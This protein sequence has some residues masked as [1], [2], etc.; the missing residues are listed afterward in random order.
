MKK[1]LV[2]L[3][4]SWG[5]RHGGL[6]VVNYE[7]CQHFAKCESF[8]DHI[9]CITL[10]KD[11][12]LSQIDRLH[13]FG[14]QENAL[15]DNFSTSDKY[16]ILEI[17]ENN[18]FVPICFIGHDAK[19]GPIANACTSLY[20]NKNESQAK[21]VVFHHM[22]YSSY[23]SLK[24]F[25]DIEENE[26][27]LNDQITTL[28]NADIIIP[29]GPKL[30]K[31]AKDKSE[32][33]NKLIDF[34]PGFPYI[35]GKAPGSIFSMITF[36]RFSKSVNKLKQY[37]VPIAAFATLVKDHELGND[38]QIYV[39]GMGISSKKDLKK[40]QNYVLKYS[41]KKRIALNPSP[42]YEDTHKI[43]S[44]LRARSVSVM[45]SL[46]EGFGLTGWESIA[47]EVPLVVT[48]NSG[49]YEFLKSL[50]DVDISGVKGV[51][52]D[53]QSFEILFINQL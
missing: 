48:Q 27:K 15:T 30:H 23:I 1:S 4:T 17:L 6:N 44:R 5:R 36:G 43:Y 28:K 2:F 12:P 32:D 47:A 22:D 10:D 14:L 42:Y 51:I 9:V 40:L 41:G 38:P 18:G 11:L 31:S 29:V 39:M 19:T 16:E 50:R 21:S 33:E 37:H 46:H 8:Y 34:I 3:S 45:P 7:V 52:I 49:L 24:G 13:L 20:N 35:E 53:G 25:D 26:N